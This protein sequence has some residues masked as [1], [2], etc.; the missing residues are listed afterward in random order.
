MLSASSD[1]DRL[2]RWLQTCAVVYREVLELE[3]QALRQP[4]EAGDVRAEIAV[5]SPVADGLIACL[6]G[7]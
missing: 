4:R 2:L 7:H 6:L 5:I 1:R 3:T